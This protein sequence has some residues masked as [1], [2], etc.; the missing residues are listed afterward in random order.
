MIFYALNFLFGI[1]VF[2]QKSTISFSN[3]DLLIGILLII[4]LILLF[5]FY[6][7]LFFALLLFVLGFLY[8]GIHS[9]N[10]LSN[11]IGLNYLNK[12]ITVVGNITNLVKSKGHK[13][14]F[15]L[16]T[17]KPFT[18]NIKLSWYGKN[19]PKLQAG[20]TW[21]LRVKLKN[22]NG[23]KN[24]IGF[25]YEKSLFINNID[26][27]GY[28]II[29][30][31]AINKFIKLSNQNII[32]QARQ[33]IKNTLNPYLAKLEN[34]NI[35][36][37]LISGDRA[38]ISS[39]E[40]EIF[41]QTNTSHLTVVSGLHIGIISGFVFF[42]ALFFYKLC[43]RCCLRIPAQIFASYAG[44]ISAI[45][46][47]LLAG[48]SVSTQRASVMAITVF[49]SIISKKHYPIWDLYAYALFAV[50]IIEPLSALSIGFWLS[51][52]AVALILYGVKAYKNLSKIPRMLSIQLLIS[53]AMLPILLWFF[54]GFGFS[55]F[56]ANTIA[57]P[58]VSFIALPS[59]LLGAI[60][61]LLDFNLLTN[62]LF[63]IADYSLYI[64]IEVLEYLK[65]INIFNNK[66]YYNYGIESIWQLLLIIICFVIIFLPK[67]LKFRRFGF[68]SLLALFSYNKSLGFEDN[69]FIVEVMDSGQGLAIIIQTKNHNLLFDTGFSSVSGFNIGDSV[70]MP[71]MFKKNIRKIDTV[72]VS[73]SDNDHIG[74]LKYINKQIAIGEIFTSTPKQVQKIV[75]INNI[76][77]CDK[78]QNWVYDNINFSILHPN[79]SYKL[80]NKKT[81]NNSCVL[82]ISNGKYSILITADIEKNAE[83]YLIK[84]ASKKLKA[85]I[86]LV[87]HHGSNTSSTYDFLIAVSP[88]IAINSSGYSNRFSHPS[89]KVLSRYN[90]LNI[91]LY[92]TQCSG[93]I[94]LSI[95]D[96][97]IINEARK[98]N[99]NYWTRV[100]K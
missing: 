62:W 64:I 77:T 95:G 41:R 37:A 34:G 44:I 73:H 90:A 70:I 40:W 56:I 31:P 6:K 85:D 91:P 19:Q 59:S 100:C 78:G 42:I 12:H 60:S 26:A 27:T 32:N 93:Q 1:V 79:K 3:F 20:E 8:M 36:Y 89:D 39:E 92:D 88:T 29:K 50:L 76:K 5:K 46:Y 58:I 4:T 51:F 57:I 24:K 61:A 22:N 25:D 28:V 65:N 43:S 83:K 30:N 80:T 21:R 84:N 71:Y 87:P 98:D 16:S 69:K 9:H 63:Y 66:L 7:K 33:K 45:T 74:G 72:I 68:I 10:T 35:I 94:T 54:S 99:K 81:N 11:N 47:A 2:S 15:T 17:Y 23:L 49:A 75:N 14:S 48:F 82:K 52:I 97:I 86:L 13:T 67:G 38:G 53:F 18:A 55:S 96:D